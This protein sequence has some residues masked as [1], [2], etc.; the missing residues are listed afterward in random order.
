L[1]RKIFL[2]LYSFC[3]GIAVPVLRF[4]S[5]M[6]EGY[7]QRSLDDAYLEKADL[8]IQAASVGESNMAETLLRNL[9]PV[10]PL[11]ILVTSNTSQ[12]MGILERA[13]EGLSSHETLVSVH[14]AYFPFDKPS[15]MEKAVRMI[16]PKV[17]VLLE[18]E[19]WPGLMSALKNHGSGM[20]II[21]GRIR[22]KSLDKYMLWPSLWRDIAPDKI[23]AISEEDAERFGTLFGPDR[24]DV[25]GNIKF[26]QV[27]KEGEW[28]ARENP[29]K[30]VVSEGTPF[31]VLGSVRREEEN[32]VA[33][34]VLDIVHRKPDTVIGLFPRHI[35]RV[36]YWQDKLDSLSMP[37]ITRS[38]CKGPVSG[39]K[40]IIWDTFGELFFAYDLAAAAFIGGSLAPLG[41]QNFIE[42]L[43]CG[44]SPIIGPSWE[45][46]T[47]VGDDLMEKGLVR[48]RPDWKS[49]A[50]SILED[51]E[52]PTDRANVRESALE[53]IKACRGGTAEACRVI[54]NMMN[55]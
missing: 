40:S 37:W 33:K 29:L 13:I 12:G 8:W 45:N 5:R 55:L 35:H 34:I 44:V 30:G 49:V 41:G 42:P 38:E 7:E 15:L 6:A 11:K 47:W 28:P 24:V 17:M 36:K 23:L 14:A 4:N 51:L 48:I 1:S 26:D 50:D 53:Y 39:G 31:V 2:G 21:N 19:M 32:A 43:F 9:R 22:Q 18:S 52:R 20:V 10:R 25:M 54:L 3:W 16:N 27:S 46:F